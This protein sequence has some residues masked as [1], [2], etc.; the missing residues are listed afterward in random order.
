VSDEPRNRGLLGESADNAFERGYQAG[1]AFSDIER[2]REVLRSLLGTDAY[3][4]PTAAL[5]RAEVERRETAR[6]LRRLCK[7]L[8]ASEDWQDVDHLADVVERIHKDLQRRID[9]IRYQ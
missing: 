6:A 7:E 2:L 9:D 4:N 5:A 1:R 3:N 8:G